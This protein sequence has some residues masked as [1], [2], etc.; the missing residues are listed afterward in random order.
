M[1]RA[2]PYGFIIDHEDK[3]WFAEYHTSAVTRFDPVTETFDRFPI[4]SNPASIRRLGIDSK[5]IVW[6][7]VYGSQ[8]RQGKLGRVDPATGEVIELDLPIPFS[9]PYDA[10]AD[11]D[12][13]IW[14]STSNYLVK[15]TQDDGK[16]TLYQT[17]TRTD[18]PKMSITK[19]GAIWFTPRNAGLYGGLGGAASVLYPDMD[20]MTTM[21]AYYSDKNTA[22][23]LAE[24]EGEGVQVT[25]VVKITEGGEVTTEMVRGGGPATVEEPSKAGAM[26][27]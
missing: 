26:A 3:I 8:D 22:N 13:N 16:M 15:Y 2:R 27:D 5:G 24:F 12:D 10:W 7:G 21:A 19:G 20:K 6:F 25:G 18:M 17:P 23:H 1:S 4:K 9:N 14:A 11:D